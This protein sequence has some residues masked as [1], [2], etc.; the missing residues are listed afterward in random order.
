MVLRISS[1]LIHYN[2]DIMKTLFESIL[3]STGAGA[4]KFT[5]DMLVRL[6]H[7]TSGFADKFDIKQTISQNDI[8][9]QALCHISTGKTK[10]DA[11]KAL[12][13]PIEWDGPEE[14]FF[15][16]VFKDYLIDPKKFDF[17]CYTEDDRKEVYVATHEKNNGKGGASQP[18]FTLDLTKIK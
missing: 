16:D 18:L 8:I 17:F 15:K 14:P 2:E 5:P 6:G 1:N 13:H 9:W 7:S 11:Q 3:K 12:I 4:F 10:K